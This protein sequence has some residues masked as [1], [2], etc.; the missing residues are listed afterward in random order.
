M[1]V[2]NIM[3]HS[4]LIHQYYQADKIGGV[5][6]GRWPVSDVRPCISMARG[7][8]STPTCL[9]AWK[10]LLFLRSSEVRNIYKYIHVVH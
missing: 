10:Y 2:D 1:Y 8:N 3:L 7:L 4:S 9:Y 6:D 5:A